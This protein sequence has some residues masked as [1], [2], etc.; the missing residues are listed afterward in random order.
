MI[1]NEDKQMLE[2][3]LVRLN[4]IKDVKD[5]EGGK[6][7]LAL[8]GDAI[9]ATVGLLSSTYID[10]PEAQIRALCATLKANLELYQTLSGCESQIESIQK[11]VLE[12]PPQK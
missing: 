8:T 3:E 4:H 11:V 12:N 2:D 7:I 9:V 10:A 1:E 5:M 6:A